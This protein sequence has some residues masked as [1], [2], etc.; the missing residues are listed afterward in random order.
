MFSLLTQHMHAMYALH[1]ILMLIFKDVVWKL[2]A[3]KG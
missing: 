3:S 1:N 2:E